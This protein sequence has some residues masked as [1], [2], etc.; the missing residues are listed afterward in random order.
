MNI[1]L[2]K[3]DSV[4]A[5]ITI[6]VEK[7]DYA[8]EV[9]NSLKDLRKNAV[10]PGFRKGMIPPELL[11]QKYGKAILI[12]EINKLLTKNLDNYIKDNNLPVLGEPLPAEEQAPLDFDTQE[13]FAFIF[14]IGLS[15]TIDIRLTKED[16]MPYYLIQATDDMILKQIEQVKAQHGDYIKVEELEDIDVA[17]GKLIELGENGEPKE[18]AITNESAVLMPMYMKD[19][20]EKVKFHN[21]KLH[22]TI[23][24]NPSKAY[25]GIEVELASFLNINKDLV[26]DHTGDFSFEI[27]EITR[28]KEAEIN[29]DLFDKVFEPGTVQSEEMFREKIKERLTQQM[30]PESDYKFIL[31]AKNLLLEKASDIQLP[32]ALLKRWLLESN[33]KQTPESLVEDYPKIAEDLKFHLIQNH[34]NEENGITAEE[35]EIEE[36]AQKTTRNQFAQ[37]GMFDIPDDLLENYSR[38]MLKKKETYHSLR[39]KVLED[40]LIK[41]LK[42]QATLEPQNI[43]LEDFKKLIN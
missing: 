16:K 9:D 40:K 33:S 10:F 35:S 27:N 13:N 24:F 11:R 2:N 38:E 36:Y 43:T 41:V 22:S 31:D 7:A 4:N 23:I 6:E 15:P 12:E 29:Q 25:A 28:Y 17:K 30:S 37:Y 21:A 39:D 32:D 19:E 14:D 42:E 8:N 1:T 3:K 34:L 5:T 26:K 18:D 20:E